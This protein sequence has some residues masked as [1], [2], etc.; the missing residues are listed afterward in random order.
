MKR[1]R[2]SYAVYNLN[3]RFSKEKN[4]EEIV[5]CSLF[6]PSVCSSCL[7]WILYK[8]RNCSLFFGNLLVFSMA[9]GVGGFA[10]KKE[11][12]AGI[13]V[14]YSKTF[15]AIL[16]ASMASSSKSRSLPSPAKSFL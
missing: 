6:D 16:C 11:K 8:F 12:I 3:S 1:Y 10:N 9:L 7:D 4:G 15:S 13:D 2:V 5:S 14:L